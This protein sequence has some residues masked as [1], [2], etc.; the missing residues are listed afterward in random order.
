[1][2]VTDEKSREKIGFSRRENKR[3]IAQITS[4]RSCHHQRESRLLHPTS[5][6]ARL[7]F[8]GGTIVVAYMPAGVHPDYG[9]SA[10]DISPCW[11]TLEH[12]QKGSYPKHR[13]IQRRLQTK[14]CVTTMD[15]SD[16]STNEI[17]HKIPPDPPA[18]TNENLSFSTRRVLVLLSLGGNDRHGSHANRPIFRQRYTSDRH[19]AVLDHT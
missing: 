14:K 10:I 17:L 16:R 3:N 5:P 15:F 11:T 13:E 9:I 2:T 19:T 8:F 7:T 1:M 6:R 4:R 18:T 12:M